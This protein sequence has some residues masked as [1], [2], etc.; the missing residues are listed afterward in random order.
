MKA[1]SIIKINMSS[2]I[3]P[4]V[5]VKIMLRKKA[6]VIFTLSYVK[7][8]YRQHKGTDHIRSN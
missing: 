4:N 1:Y 7:N 6:K 8:S 5:K 2:I 3:D